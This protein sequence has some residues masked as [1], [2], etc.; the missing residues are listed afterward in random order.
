MDTVRF[1]FTIKDLAINIPKGEELTC[2]F[3]QYKLFVC[4]EYELRKYLLSRGNHLGSMKFRKKSTEKARTT[5][6]RWD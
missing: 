4:V 5:K 1:W 3:I 2:K 6:Q